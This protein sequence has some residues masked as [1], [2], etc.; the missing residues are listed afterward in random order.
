MQPSLSMTVKYIV[1]TRQ[2]WSFFCTKV[3]G[4]VHTYTHTFIY[5]FYKPKG[6]QHLQIH[7]E[8]VGVKKFNTVLISNTLKPLADV[9]LI[10]QWDLRNVIP[11]PTITCPTTPNVQ[12]LPRQNVQWLGSGINSSDLTACLSGYAAGYMHSKVQKA[13]RYPIARTTY[14]EII[15]VK[16][17]TF[18]LVT[19]A[20]GDEG[21][22]MDLSTKHLATWCSSTCP[23]MWVQPISSYMGT[24]KAMPHS[25]ML[26]RTLHVWI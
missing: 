6:H 1:H 5:F 22:F 9:N 17:A 23:H 26:G 25:R 12:S 10:P 15:F 24:F 20:A 4:V 7:N 21:N 16:T 11:V 14:P 19:Q 3:C 13:P 2:T 18:I 8:E